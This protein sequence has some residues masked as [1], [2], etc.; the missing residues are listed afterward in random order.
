M[1]SKI[2]CAYVCTIS[3]HAFR[4]EGDLL[5]GR[6]IFKCIIFQSTPSVWKAT[7][8]STK[9]RLAVL[10]QSTPSVW[11]ATLQPCSCSDGKAISIHAFRVEGDEFSKSHFRLFFGFQSTPSVWKATGCTCRCTA[12]ISISIH[13]FRVEGD[14]LLDK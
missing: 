4:V 3:I 5:K 13:A 7:Y 1:F 11:K 6:T 9:N 2:R 10:F 14:I 8:K 12:T